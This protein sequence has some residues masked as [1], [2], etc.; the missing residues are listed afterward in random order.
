ML[1]CGDPPA[2]RALTSVSRSPPARWWKC[3]STFSGPASPTS[4]CQPWSGLAYSSE[5]RDPE[6]ETATR[7]P[8]TDTVRVRLAEGGEDDLP[9]RSLVLGRGLRDPGVALLEG[10]P[11]PGR[12]V[13]VLPRE[14][15]GAGDDTF[16]V[17][18]A[19]DRAF[20]VG[21]AG[22]R[23]V[24]WPPAPG[25]ASEVWSAPASA[26]EPGSEAACSTWR[27]ARSIANQ[28]KPAT[29]TT[30]SDHASTPTTTIRR[31]PTRPLCQPGTELDPPAVR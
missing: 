30:T 20:L 13:V 11:A 3:T 12:D 14:A 27:P 4:T 18:A 15:R 1:T 28:E 21:L 22:C 2:Q 23:G 16:A 7:P 8:D 19:A 6:Q 17:G 25:P 10:S 29:T 9:G 24:G 31:G 26:P 5:I